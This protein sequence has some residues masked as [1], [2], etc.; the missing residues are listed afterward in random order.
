LLYRWR[1][2]VRGVC[3]RT[4][5]GLGIVRTASSD[6]RLVSVSNNSNPTGNHYKKYTVRGI[7]GNRSS[8]YSAIHEI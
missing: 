6:L 3:Y 8:A 5:P 2:G 7:F 4:T 1:G